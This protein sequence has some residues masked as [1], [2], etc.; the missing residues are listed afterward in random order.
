MLRDHLR[1][2]KEIDLDREYDAWT[3]EQSD[4]LQRHWA[5]YYHCTDDDGRSVR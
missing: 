1:W 2:R 4:K 3:A 5:Q